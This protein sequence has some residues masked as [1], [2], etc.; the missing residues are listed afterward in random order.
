[1]MAQVPPIRRLELDTPAIVRATRARAG[2]LVCLHLPRL[3]LDT[4]LSIR[5]RLSSYAERTGVV[6]LVTEGSEHAYR[7]HHRPG[8]LIR[9]PGLV[10]GLS[11]LIRPL[12]DVARWPFEQLADRVNAAGHSL[13][14]ALGRLGARCGR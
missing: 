3:E 7:V 5:Q 10:W 12:G 1:M 13:S 4:A 11:D 14:D 8:L 9:L 2:D 6:F